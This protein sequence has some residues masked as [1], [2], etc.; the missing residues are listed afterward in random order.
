[1]GSGGGDQN[2]GQTPH[3]HHHPACPHHTASLEPTRLWCEQQKS[4]LGQ[5][6]VSALA[7]SAS[8]P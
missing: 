6:L 4:G 7:P 1:M 3:H 2:S 8:L 5:N